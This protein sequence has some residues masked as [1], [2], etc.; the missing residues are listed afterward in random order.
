MAPTIWTDSLATHK[1]RLRQHIVHT[2]A[3]LLAERGLGEVSMSLL[4]QRAGIA[5]ATLYNH[6][7][8][9]ERVLAALVADQ[10]ARFRKQLDRHLADAPDP[11]E[12]LR[13]YLL[14]VHDWAAQQR[15]QPTKR[16]DTPRPTSRNHALSPQVVA[17]THQPLGQLREILEQILVDAIASH[18]VHPDIDPGLHAD[19]VL[20]LLLDPRQPTTGHTPSADRDQLV[21]FVLRGLAATSANPSAPPQRR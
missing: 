16:A 12:R 10:V 14:A 17:T 20:K 5:R 15:R 18:A 8:D 9:F 7:P 13:R 11:A 3:E 21:R 19:L 2:A 4:A 1:Q 6:F